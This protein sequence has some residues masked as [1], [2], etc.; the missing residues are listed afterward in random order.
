MKFA[1]LFFVLLIV[2][3]TKASHSLAIEDPLKTVNNKVGI[4]ILFP[5]ELQAAAN[6]VNSNGGDWGYVTIPIQV[7]DKN[8][9]KWQQF[10]DE[11]KRLHIVPIVRLAT[12]GHYFNTA[13]WKKPSREDVLDFANFLNSLEWPVKN[14]YVI[15][16]NEVNRGDE[17]EGSPNPSEYASILDFA[18][19]AFKSKNEDFFIIS[20]GLDN[21]AANVSG[22]SMNQYSFIRE[23][24]S[25]VPNIFNKID[26]LGSHSYPNPAF[27]VPPWVVTQRSIS[28]FVYEKNLVDQFSDKNLPIF[29]TE[30]GWSSNKISK[31]QIATYFTY[32]FNSVWS[33]NN[34]IAVTPFLLQAGTDPFS[35]FSILNTDGSHNDIAFA[36]KELPKTKGTPTINFNSTISTNIA[37]KPAKI[38]E[39][40]F[41]KK[42]QY[43]NLVDSRTDAIAVFLKWLLKLP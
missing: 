2:F 3:L 23:M 40:S 41:S 34:I 30:T 31:N 22:T 42:I 13:F 1:I 18:V 35:Q 25:A 19:D 21:A 5:S 16:F 27:S 36:L 7:G 10:M 14:R 32:A 29:I 8:L 4:H 6:I 20:A 15:I 28:S 43:A 12:E 24:Y 38:P 11:A 9:E 39:K 33:N 37:S 17:W 26:G